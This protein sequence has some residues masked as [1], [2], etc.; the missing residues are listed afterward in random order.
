M[1]RACLVLWAVLFGAMAHAQAPAPAPS[2][3]IVW[4]DLVLVDGSTLRAADL[5]GKTVVVQMW[6]TW[7]PFCAK[8]NPH[9]HALHEQMRGKGLV[10][11][12]FTIDRSAQTAQA[13]LKERG[14]SFPSAMSSPQVEAW[15][16]KRRTLPEI[17]VVDPAGRVVFR[18]TGEMFA[19][20]IAA[21]ARFAPAAR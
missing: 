5:R 19:E 18:E 21:L 8:Q 12:G 3:P 15:F 7:C 4:T 6:A 17:Y 10:V 20:D 9:V 2:A 14:Y 11:L 13:Y 1:I 16:G